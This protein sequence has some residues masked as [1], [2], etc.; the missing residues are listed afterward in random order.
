M[1]PPPVYFSLIPHLVSSPFLG[2]SYAI[3]SVQ[4]PL[5]ICLAKS[6]SF[7]RCQLKKSQ[8]PFPWVPGCWSTSLPP[9]APCASPET[10]ELAA[11]LFIEH[12]LREVRNLTRRM[13][14]AWGSALSMGLIT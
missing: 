11:F 1:T 4:S 14:L 10:H 12:K 3:T 6:S 5:L 8:G 13:H 7:S 2:L 9:P